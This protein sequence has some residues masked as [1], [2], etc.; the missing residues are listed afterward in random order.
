MYLTFEASPKAISRRTSYLRVRLEFH[1]YPHAHP[2]TFQR[3][4]VRSSTTFY[5]RFN[6]HM[7]RSPGF[8][9]TACNYSPYSDSLS[10]RLRCSSTLTSLHT[11]NSPARSTKSTW[12]LALPLE[13]LLFYL[14][15]GLP[16]DISIVSALMLLILWSAGNQTIRRGMLMPCRSD[17]RP[18]VLPTAGLQ[19]NQR[20][21]A[22][23]FTRPSASI[24]CSASSTLAARVS[25]VS[26]GTK[27]Q[28][29]ILTEQ[30]PQPQS[31][32]LS[33]QYLHQF[34]NERIL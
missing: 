29:I 22:A 8:G 4:W 34:Q 33:F 7:D 32:L 17:L 10:L 27:N 14:C 12:S 24:S 15:P 18:H 6:L 20:I 31:L 11:S 2:S 25:G 5:R 21:C 30:Q 9:S 28:S 3:T 19:P 16:D 23:T 1:R 26:S 13:S